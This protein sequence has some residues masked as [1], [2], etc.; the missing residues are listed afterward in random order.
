[1]T[2]SLRRRSL[3]L[4]GVPA[5]L[6]PALG[7]AQGGTTRIDFEKAAIGY[8][9]PGF[10]SALTGAGGPPNWTIV[11]DRTAPAGSHSLAQ[12]SADRTDYR[13]PLAILD[14]A[15]PAD[16]DVTVRFKPISGEIDRAA[17]IAVRLK[18]ANNYYVVRA[19]A[20]EDNVRLYRVVGG[21]RIQ[22]AG[23]SA[24][25][26]TGVWQELRLRVVA[27]RFEVFL[28]GRSLYVANDTAITSGGRVALWTKADSVTYFDELIVKPPA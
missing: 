13:F 14:E 15:Q 20:L 3:L 10:T 7:H 9:P 21:R 26:P 1:M 19:N 12:T 23:S 27:T 25:V 4:A 11:E 2:R 22:F 6:L 28:G 16:I 18:D 5:V 8:L 24:K 17:G